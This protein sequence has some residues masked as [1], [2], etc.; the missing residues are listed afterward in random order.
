MRKGSH[1]YSILQGKKRECYVTGEVSQ[2]EKHHIYF[3]N[4]NRKISDKN[5]F[6]VFLTTELHRGVNGVHGKNGHALDIQLKQTC[7]TKYEASHTRED[8]I[9]LIGR[10]YID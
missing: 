6:W 5:G 8:F 3:G 4:P 10:N 7:Q 9:Q 2:L 1:K